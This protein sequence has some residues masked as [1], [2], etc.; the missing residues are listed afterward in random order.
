MRRKCETRLESRDAFLNEA[1]RRK[2]RDRKHGVARGRG[3]P[4]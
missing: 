4:R 1:T 3:W 2:K